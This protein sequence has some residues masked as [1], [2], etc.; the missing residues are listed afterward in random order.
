MQ[1]ATE[2]QVG[3]VGTIN[4]FREKRKIKLGQK[5]K[6]GNERVGLGKSASSRKW[7]I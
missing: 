4:Y 3:W 2:A 6:L 1:F 7:G 5:F